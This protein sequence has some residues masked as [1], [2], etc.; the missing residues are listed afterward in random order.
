MAPM[1]PKIPAIGVTGSAGKSTTTAF[2]Y[3]ILKVKWRNVIKTK[4]NLNLPKHTKRNVQR[5]KPSHKAVILE[6]GLGRSSGKNHFRYIKPNFGIITSVG[7]AHFG[8]LGNSIKATARAKSV[9]IQYMN[10]KGTLL[11]NQDDP[12][13]KLLKTNAFKGNL[14]TVGVNKKARYQ[15]RNIRYLRNGMSFKVRLNNKIEHFFIP[16]FGKHN[17]INALFAIAI[18]H[19]LRF[20]PSQ[21]RL[22]LRRY[23]APRRRLNVVPLKNNSL[24]I[25]DTFNANP[26]S[27][28]A[29]I[30]VLMKLGEGKEKQV[31]IGSMLELGRYSNRGHRIVGRYL[32]SKKVKKIFLYG[33][34]A[35]WI[36][37]AAIAAGYP[38]RN[39][40]TFTNRDQLHK[41]LKKHIT[42]NNVVLV[43]GSH[44]MG[45]RYTANFLARTYRK[46]R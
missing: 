26:Q 18:A 16:T 22:G 21:M 13:S 44:R 27:V 8:K 43:K 9:M 25:D 6:M 3:S 28:K 17:V 4:G 33:K 32:A 41:M 39:I 31:V 40:H 45:M 11:I 15:A 30:D 42:S 1:I 20:S 38:R 36:K 35:R 29:A 5:I 2:I 46:K 19:R 37:K 23:K 12:N 10:P 14:V 7:T 24:L 34:K